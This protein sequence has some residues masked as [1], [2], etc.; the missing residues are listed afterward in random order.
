MFYLNWKIKFTYY[1]FNSFYKNNSGSLD[2]YKDVI[3]PNVQNSRMLESSLLNT[4]TLMN[5]IVLIFQVVIINLVDIGMEIML[6][7]LD[8][9]LAYVLK[10][11]YITH[12]I[13]QVS[14][15]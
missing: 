8:L 13:V 7:I 3:I 10:V 9:R 14:K 11:N 6:H 15:T 4:T 5:G 1:S 12:K 2:W